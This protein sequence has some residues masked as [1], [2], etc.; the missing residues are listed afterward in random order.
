MLVKKEYIFMLVTIVIFLAIYS[1][2]LYDKIDFFYILILT[3]ATESVLISIYN[4]ADKT[5]SKDIFIYTE[6]TNQFLRYFAFVV[7]LHML[8]LSMYV[9]Y[10]K[11]G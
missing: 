10:N 4:I 2:L 3:F 9:T 11:L 1:Y 6:R 7:S 8:C 5:A